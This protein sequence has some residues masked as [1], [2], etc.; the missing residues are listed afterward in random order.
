MLMRVLH[1]IGRPADALGLFTDYR[2]RL[3]DELGVEP[4]PDLRAAHRAVLNG[5][6]GPAAPRRRADL[7]SAADRRRRDRWHQR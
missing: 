6:R 5:T 7:R 4:G 1:A 3:V 2:R